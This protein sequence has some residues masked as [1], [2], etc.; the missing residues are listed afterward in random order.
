M[1][2]D[3]N[4]YGIGN[5]LVDIQYQVDP[6]FFETAG[7]EKGVMTLIEEDRHMKLIEE[8]GDKV[9][10]RSSG[11]SAANTMI[12]VANLGGQA[13]YACKVA[14]DEYGDF[15]LQDLEAAGVS[16]RLANREAGTTGK[17]L[18]L[19][20]PDADRTMN[21]F[22]GIT[23]TFG[24]DQLEEEVIARSHYLY[25]EGYLVASDAGFDAALRAQEMGKRWGAKV[26]LT[27]SDPFIVNVF[28]SRVQE[29]V[30]KGVDL[31][32]C[33]ED[34]AKAFT[35]EGDTRAACD[36]LKET[37][38]GY[39][40]TCGPNGAIVFDRDQLVESP[41]FRVEAVDTN[42]AGDMFAGAYIFGLTHGY[43]VIQSA[44][45]AT[46]ASAQVVAQ[47]GPRLEE[48]LKDRISEILDL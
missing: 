48:S 16:S 27:L 42:G 8:L 18:V 32:F 38:K 14:K 15:Y 9:L 3:Y 6:D 5:A 46:Y 23:A 36:S 4:V 12:S 39:A 1:G 37:V 17:C 24:P 47:F 33:N 29:L 40:V 7:I 34:E 44:K 45:L 2:R 13:Y 41:G 28:K 10:K 20:T 25:I 31:L 19:I 30:E 21:T 22:L 11:G 35:G 43:D 26:A